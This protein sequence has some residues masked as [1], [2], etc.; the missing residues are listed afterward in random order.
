M[1]KVQPDQDC[2]I[3]DDRIHGN[4]IPVKEGYVHIGCID[5]YHETTE[6]RSRQDGVGGDLASGRGA[7][8]GAWNKEV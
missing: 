7:T 4:P 1:P 6:A 3:C 5:E 2:I 8:A